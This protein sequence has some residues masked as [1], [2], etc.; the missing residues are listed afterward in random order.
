[1]NIYMNSS[2]QFH[3]HLQAGRLAA[4]ISL[5]VGQIVEIDIITNATPG[6]LHTKVNLLTGQIVS[7][8]DPAF[9]SDKAYQRLLEFHTNQIG[10]ASQIVREQLR[11]LQDL[12]HTVESSQAATPAVIPA[13]APVTETSK[14][15]VMVGTTAEPVQKI[16]LEK[17]PANPPVSLSDAPVMELEVA[18]VTIVPVAPA[19]ISTVPPVVSNVE[20]PPS[21]AVTTAVVSPVTPPVKPENKLPEVKMGI[22]SGLAAAV[23]QVGTPNPSEAATIPNK[24]DQ[25]LKSAG[26]RQDTEEVHPFVPNSVAATKSPATSPQPLPDSFA[27]TTGDRELIDLL[28]E[29]GDDWDEWLLEEDNILSELSEASDLMTKDKLADKSMGKVGG[30]GGRPPA[31]WDEFLPEYDAA[32]NKNQANVERFRQNLVNDPQ[33]MS[34]LLAEL[35]D[36]EQLD[37]EKPRA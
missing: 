24:F 17:V 22:A 34:E 28:S 20:P 19:D 35:D 23:A 8:V 1:L 16:E 7:T 9:V 10:A 3:E 12:L 6:S 13:P 18:P 11:S 32:A 31:E 21:P 36:I 15:R 25:A 2:E 14:V 29:S 5:V 37:G 27:S 26:I 33:L 30:F 4:A